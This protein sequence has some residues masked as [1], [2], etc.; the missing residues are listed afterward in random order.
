M[1]AANM[2]RDQVCAVDVRVSGPDRAANRRSAHWRPQ[3]SKSVDSR[4]RRRCRTTDAVR[5]SVVEFKKQCSRFV[6][7]RLENCTKR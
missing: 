6:A 4:R 1:N 3:E 5:R 7:N 2:A